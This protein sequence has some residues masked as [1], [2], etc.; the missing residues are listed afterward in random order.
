MTL[1]QLQAYRLALRDKLRELE[2]V[3]ATCHGCDHFATGRCALF[4]EVPPDGFQRT[5]EACEAWVYDGVPF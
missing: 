4:D 2:R 1:Q 5:P 3:D